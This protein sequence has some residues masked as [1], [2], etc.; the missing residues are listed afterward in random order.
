MTSHLKSWAPLVSLVLV[1]GLVGCGGG[2]ET[3]P[4]PD[5][6]ISTPDLNAFPP[7][8]QPTADQPTP[9]EPAVEELTIE[10]TAPVEIPVP[11]IS[12]PADVTPDAAPPTGAAPPTETPQF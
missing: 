5:T 3:V 10:E 4:P 1:L 12:P 9:S 6:G 2:E 11:E 8:D 7:P